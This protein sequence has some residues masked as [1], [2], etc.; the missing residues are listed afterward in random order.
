MQPNEYTSTRLVTRSPAIN[1]GAVLPSHPPISPT[2]SAYPPASPSSRPHSSTHGKVRSRSAGAFCLEV[3]YCPS[4]WYFFL[5]AY[6]D[7]PMD[8][9]TRMEIAN[10]PRDLQHDVDFFLVGKSTY[11]KLPRKY[12]TRC[13]PKRSCVSVF[14]P[15]S[16][17]R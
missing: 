1:S 16:I 13:F 2:C 7:V 6:F 15:S 3:E 11:R 9:V 14:P 10:R 8:H 4:R 12:F 17:T 5:R